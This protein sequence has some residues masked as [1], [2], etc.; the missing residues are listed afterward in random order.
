M[1]FSISLK[2]GRIIVDYSHSGWANMRGYGGGSRSAKDLLWIILACILFFSESAQAQTDPNHISL[3]SEQGGK[4]VLDFLLGYP[5]LAGGIIS[6]AI[7]AL[8]LYLGLTN[9]IGSSI[10]C[11]LS[12]S[13]EEDKEPTHK[14]NAGP[15]PL[16][17]KPIALT[18]AN[19]SQLEHIRL[20]PFIEEQMEIS[21]ACEAVAERYL[22][23]YRDADNQCWI[24]GGLIEMA[25]SRR[26]K[27]VRL[28]LDPET[29][30]HRIPEQFIRCT[31]GHEHPRRIVF[32]TSLGERRCSGCFSSGDG[33]KLMDKVLRKFNVLLPN[34]NNV[35]MREDEL[36]A[37]KRFFGVANQDYMSLCYEYGKIHL[38]RQI[39]YYM[40][41]L[42][43]N[44]I[45]RRNALF[46]FL[47]S[48]LDEM[49]HGLF[50]AMIY[51]TA[52]S[53][54]VLSVYSIILH[55]TPVFIALFA[56]PVMARIETNL[57]QLRRDRR[58]SEDDDSHW[59]RRIQNREAFG[60]IKRYIRVY[61]Y[62]YVGILFLF[63]LMIHSGPL[64]GGSESLTMV[65]LT[66]AFFLGVFLAWHLLEET[67][68]QFITEIMEEVDAGEVVYSDN[69]VKAGFASIG[70]SISTVEGVFSQL[71]MIS[72]FMIGYGVYHMG[73]YNLMLPVF[74][75]I[76]FGGV[77][78]WFAYPLFFGD[79]DGVY[80]DIEQVAY[81]PGSQE[82]SLCFSGNIE[83]VFAPIDKRL[84][85]IEPI[86]VR[87]GKVLLPWVGDLG[88][89][90]RY[91]TKPK[92]ST[93]KRFWIMKYTEIHGVAGD[94]CIAIKKRMGSVSRADFRI[95][96]KKCY[97]IAL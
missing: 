34:Y 82:N 60:K 32:L 88:V 71:F 12:Q 44:R 48:Y 62:T 94:P 45:Y 4:Y 22:L 31:I 85:N 40:A 70:D 66:P 74:F 29:E 3:Y 68:G 14:E 1:A 87:E 5:L 24:G 69:G 2:T 16:Y 81:L 46:W 67:L 59:D 90:L 17:G 7:L 23:V 86:D 57:V 50:I 51:I 8:L 95:E 93:K 63:F 65:Q 11:A 96:K 83:I 43:F 84:R 27:S 92:I 78:C 28:T 73:L 30:L 72:S 15:L 91:K 52:E 89:V 9:R 58:S 47:C 41:L 33:R 64:E 97:E 10:D 25:T 56:W 75:I 35:P 39:E 36:E 79:D 38:W 55:I 54:G 19:K 37:A 49:L 42:R 76:G 13:V 80:L 53:M 61:G 21:A 6:T 77:A 26:Q 20:S 18:N